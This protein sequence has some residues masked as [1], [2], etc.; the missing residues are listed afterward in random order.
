MESSVTTCNVSINGLAIKTWSDTATN[1]INNVTGT[2]KMGK[3]TAEEILNILL[4]EA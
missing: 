3:P 2:V 4:G 1:S